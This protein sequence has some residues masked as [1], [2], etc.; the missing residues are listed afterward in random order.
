MHKREHDSDSNIW[1][2]C[3]ADELTGLKLGDRRLEN[4]AVRIVAAMAQAPEKS[5]PQAVA[6]DAELQGAYGLIGNKRVTADK[7]LAPHI[8]RTVERVGLCDE[9][10]VAHDTSEFE[11]GGKSQRQGLGRLRSDKH[12]GFLGHVSLAL[13]AASRRPLGVL[14]L[15]P[16]ARTDPPKPN[17]NAHGKKKSGADY[18]K[19]TDKESARWYQ[20]VEACAQRVEQPEKLIHVMDREAD[21]FELL[22]NLV[23][24]GHRFVV[25]LRVDR[26]ARD[27][28]TLVPGHVRAMTDKAQDV[29]I[30]EVPISRRDKSN[31]PALAKTFPA[32]EARVAKL[33]F[34]ATT[35][36]LRRPSYLDKA[37]YPDWL[38]VNIVQVHELDVPEGMEPVEWTLVTTEPIDTPE[39]IR[40]VVQLYQS[41]WTIEEFFKAL[42]TGC[43]VEKAQ[44]ESLGALLN[45][46]A[47]TIP[48]AWQLL[49]LRNLA[50]TQPDAPAT[51][52]LTPTQIEVLRDQ[53][54]LPIPEHPT[55]GVAALAIAMMGGYIRSRRPYGW[56]TLGRGLEKLTTLT[57]GWLAAKRQA[58]DG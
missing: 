39:Q 4:R 22:S 53:S 36:Q 27:P 16:W 6:D 21:A 25:R 2:P 49:L 1:A 47:L 58:L 11:Y 13:H 40:R 48:V 20:Q 8:A 45:L 30:L 31:M 44:L 17:R 9:V 46:L 23:T 12:Q 3:A 54:R 52:V 33:A 38:L 10:V 55:I 43:E 37:K 14:A 18:A 26:A 29:L 35:L 50:R 51:E 7:L 32:R 5:L 19:E 56:L 57:A 34:R 42:K 15:F 24:N 41:R 28:E